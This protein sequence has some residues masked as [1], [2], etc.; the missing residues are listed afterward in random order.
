MCVSDGIYINGSGLLQQ[1]STTVNMIKYALGGA[2]QTVYI[3]FTVVGVG[4][5][6]CIGNLSPI[7]SISGGIPGLHLFNFMVCLVSYSDSQHQIIFSNLNF[8]SKILVHC[9][10]YLFFSSW[11]E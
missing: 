4:S 6:F 10:T 5:L 9:E 1:T 8:E 7:S 2:R 3:Y 11:L